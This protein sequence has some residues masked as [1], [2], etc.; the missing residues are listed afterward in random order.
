MQGE[1][2]NIAISGVIGYYFK[3]TKGTGL[4]SNV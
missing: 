3:I 1:E 4:S 2:V